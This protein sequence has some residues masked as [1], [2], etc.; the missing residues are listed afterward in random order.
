MLENNDLQPHV[1]IL[2][3]ENMDILDQK[4]IHRSFIGRI[5]HQYKWALDWE[6]MDDLFRVVQSNKL[7]LNHNYAKND[8]GLVI[9][10]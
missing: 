7:Q 5:K 2:N 1:V 4:C 8:R 6:V 10:L 3:Q 9:G